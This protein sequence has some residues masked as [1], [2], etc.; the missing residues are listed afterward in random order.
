MNSPLTPTTPPT[1]PPAQSSV[2]VVQTVPGEGAT[3]RASKENVTATLEYGVSQADL[4]EAARTGSTI[5]AMACLSIDGVTTIPVCTYRQA[6]GAYGRVEL[7]LS[8]VS[9]G[10]TKFII[11]GL[12]IRPS[13]GGSSS[14]KQI[15]RGIKPIVFNWVSP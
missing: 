1:T 10:E 2:V 5:Y 8:P 4:D 11:S 15:A 6:S 14:E 13:G 9:P 7:L 12:G 3:L